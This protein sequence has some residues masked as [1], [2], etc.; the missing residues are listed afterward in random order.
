MRAESMKLSNA[1]I[2]GKH[3]KIWFVNMCG[4]LWGIIIYN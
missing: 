4:L 2:H 1:Y 3:P